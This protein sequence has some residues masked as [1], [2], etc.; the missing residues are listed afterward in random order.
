M[1]IVQSWRKQEFQRRHVLKMNHKLG[2]KQR[3]QPQRRLGV[4]SRLSQLG[5]LG[6]RAS[7]VRWSIFYQL[8]EVLSLTPQVV[9]FHEKIT[10]IKLF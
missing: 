5:D 1:S 10:C 3:P 4:N 2:A 6:D 7:G 8:L 9:S